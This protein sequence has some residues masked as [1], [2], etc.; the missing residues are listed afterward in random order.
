MNILQNDKKIGYSHRTFRKTNKG[1]ALSEEVFMQITAMDINQEIWFLT[2][3]ALNPDLTLDNFSFKLSS[4]MFSFSAKGNM[5][6]NILVVKTGMGDEANRIEIPMETPPMLG[7]GLL[8]A[9]VIQDLPIGKSHEFEIFDPATM[10]NSK[11][12]IKVL[13][14]E[15]KKVM[16]E[17]VQATKVSIEFM[18]NAQTA[19]IGPEGEILAEEGLLGLRLEK[20]S[21]IQALDRDTIKTAGDLTLSASV[22][23]KKPI[24]NA[25]S[26]SFLSLRVKGADFY[27]KNLSGGRQ[28]YID[29]I[30]SVTKEKL[31][32]DN[33]QTKYSGDPAFL[34]SGP[35]VQSDHPEVIKQAEKIVGPDDSLQTKAQKIIDW[36]YSEL[37]KKPVFSV[38]QTL[39]TL[40]NRVGDCNEH[41]VLVAAL[42]RACGVPTQIQVGVCHLEGRF[43]YHAWN[44]FWVGKWI[45]GDAVFG[46]FPVDVTHL[47]FAS[48]GPK[49]Q[50]EMIGLL[51]QLEL[52][53]LEQKQ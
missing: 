20:V 9:A 40:R 44:L 24:N 29:G 18:G 49:V 13:G 6:E 42:A 41:A 47:R 23:I 16:G 30:L 34:A 51:G 36:A 5:Q 11:A 45:T 12:T 1:Y 28:K 43:Y 7:A 19:W 17:K 53:V 15:D 8:Y 50:M 33:I 27:K 38:P 21:R 52:T 35:F 3:G 22:Q 2:T 32:L 26:L 46:Q 37:E 25:D 39:E 14:K 31:P 4:S 10:G 48:G